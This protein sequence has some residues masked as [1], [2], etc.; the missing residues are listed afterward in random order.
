MGLSY[1]YLKTHMS[2]GHFTKVSEEYN[3][4]PVKSRGETLLC[5]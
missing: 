5:S 1:D 4:C 2:Q 3:I